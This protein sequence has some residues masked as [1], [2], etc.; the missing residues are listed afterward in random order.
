MNQSTS[1]GEHQPVILILFLGAL[2]A[3]GPIS[4]DLFVASLPLAAD[5]LGASYG[6]IQLTMT[7]VLIGFAMG[8]LIYGP[9]SDRYGRR[10]LLLVGLTLYVVAGIL[11]ATSTDLGGLVRGRWLQGFGGAA[12]MVLA[13]AWALTKV[14]TL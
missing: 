9:L 6:D 10:P 3:L 5:G 12:G 4:N 8:Q 1:R 7:A 13:A 11:C 14:E 2:N